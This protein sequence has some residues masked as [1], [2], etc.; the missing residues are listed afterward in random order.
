[1]AWLTS[2]AGTYERN[3]MSIIRRWALAPLAASLLVT[4]AA[5]SPADSGNTATDPDATGNG[6]G[7]GETTNVI[8][9]IDGSAVPYYAPLYVAQEEG[10]FAEEGLEVEFTY[11]QGSN[12]MQNV[13]AGNVDFGFPNG[14][15]VINAYGNGVEVNVVHTTYQQGIGA[16]LFSE[17]AGIESPADLAGKNVAVTDLGS[18]NYAQLQ[19]MM[20]EVDVPIE[21][22][23]VEVV[24]TGA[25]VQA[26]VNGDVDAIVFSR[27]RY[28]SLQDQGFPV[29]Q[30][31]SDEYLPSFGNVVVASKETVAEDPELVAGFVAA[32]N[33]GIQYSIDNTADAVDMAIAEY[34]DT[35]AGQEESITEVMEEVFVQNLWQS[36]FTDQHG[37]GYGDPQRW[38]DAVDAQVE[39]GIIPQSFPAD[40]MVINDD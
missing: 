37:F 35:F 10:Y 31:L 29:Q 4:L 6:N 13:A 8:L 26:L 2:L 3:N 1:M 5:C 21:E 11:D 17:E 32:L 23:S 20:R 7:S 27:L 14:D 40:E 9:Q 36:E 22:V 39:A 38:Q 16:L 28:F 34:A 33:R 12:I 24:G 30:I 25:I 18:P 19:A 15:S